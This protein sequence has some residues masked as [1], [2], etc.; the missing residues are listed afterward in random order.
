MNIEK[1]LEANKRVDDIKADILARHNKMMQEIYL[2]YRQFYSSPEL[3][4]MAGQVITEHILAKSLSCVKRKK[5]TK[6]N[7]ER[8][9]YQLKVQSGIDPLV[10]ELQEFQTIKEEHIIEVKL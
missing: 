4:L 9:I 3:R 7:K 8:E 1:V 10:P 6:L 5:Y 2:Q